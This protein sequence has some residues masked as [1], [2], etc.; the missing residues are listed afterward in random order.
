LSWIPLS[1]RETA[2][3]LGQASPPDFL[4]PIDTPVNEVI[5]TAECSQFLRMLTFVV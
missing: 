4:P 1:L 3:K 2:Y 5:A